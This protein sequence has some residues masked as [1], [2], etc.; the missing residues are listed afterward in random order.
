MTA[1][2]RLIMIALTAGAQLYHDLE[3][4]LIMTAKG[5]LHHNCRRMTSSRRQ[6]MASLRPVGYGLM[7]ARVW[8]HH[9]CGAMA[10]S[11]QWWLIPRL[12]IQKCFIPGFYT[13]WKIHPMDF[14]SLDGSSLKLSMQGCLFPWILQSW[15]FNPNSNG[16][17]IPIFQGQS[18][19]P[20]N[21]H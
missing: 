9:S 13:P 14:L 5:W 19:H 7:T 6:G 1:G 2:G 10:L 18:Y 21:F 3:G 17:I 11:M 16:P 8:L 15:I 4:C 20:K 12:Y